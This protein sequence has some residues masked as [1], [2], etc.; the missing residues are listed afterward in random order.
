MSLS[1]T[2]TVFSLRVIYLCTQMF[3]LRLSQSDTSLKT[4]VTYSLRLSLPH[5]PSLGSLSM[6]LYIISIPKLQMSWMPLHPLKWRWSL[7]RKKSPWRNKNNACAL[8]ATVDRLTNPPVPVASEHLSTRAYNEF[9]SFF[10]KIQ[11]IW[12]A[13]STTVSV[14]GDVLSFC[15]FKTNSDTMTQLD[16]ITVKKKMQDIIQH[17][18]SSFCLDILPAGFFNDFRSAAD[19]QNISSLRCLPPSHEDCSH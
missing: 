10:T 11:N 17:L 3:K 16:P 18:K 7:V 2:I 12:Q 19:C 4:L 1:L 15:P 13:V 5:H 6:T 9:S 8:F 14:T